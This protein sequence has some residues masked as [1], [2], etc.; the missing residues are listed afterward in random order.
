MQEYDGYGGNLEGRDAPC[1]HELCYQ[2][3][4]N[5]AKLDDTPSKPAERQ[6]FGPAKLEFMSG[7]DPRV[8][9]TDFEPVVYGVFDTF[10]GS[11]CYW[12]GEK[13]ESEWKWETEANEAGEK[14]SQSDEWWQRFNDGDNETKQ[15]MSNERGVALASIIGRTR[16]SE[17]VLKYASFNEAL[18]TVLVAV[19]SNLREDQDY[20]LTIFAKQGYL[21]GA[22][23]EGSNLEIMERESS[24]PRLT[25]KFHTTVAYR[26]PIHH[27]R[28]NVVRPPRTF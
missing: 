23:Y 25:G 18:D 17:R 27:R 24:T 5:P 2:R 26:W 14:N 9:V 8:T 12:T 19:E 3:A 10:D 7:Y 15:R 13:F 28:K 20:C 11:P 21:N 6:G 4:D 16:P 22:V 1:W